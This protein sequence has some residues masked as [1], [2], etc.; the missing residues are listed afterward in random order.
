VK[1]DVISKALQDVSSF[2]N[3]GTGDASMK[4]KNKKRPPSQNESVYTP[5]SRVSSLGGHPLRESKR[6]SIRNSSHNSFENPLKKS[7]SLRAN[8]HDGRGSNMNKNP[9]K[10]MVKPPMLPPSGR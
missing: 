6:N 1:S 5:G 3:G 10:K 2:E 8:S 9:T 4:S 7:S